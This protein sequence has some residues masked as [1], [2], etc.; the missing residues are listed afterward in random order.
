MFMLELFVRGTAIALAGLTLAPL[1][2]R[3]SPALRHLI[4]AIGFGWLA[5][6][7]LQGVAGPRWRPA[8]LP[9]AQLGSPG[10]N[11][12]VW[13]LAAVAR[14]KTLVL[15]QADGAPGT[16][17]FAARSIPVGSVLAGLAAAG[18]LLLLGLRG[19]GMWRVRRLIGRGRTLDA[20]DPVSRMAAH[21]AHT[22]GLAKPIP[23][24]ETAKCAAPFAAGIARPVIVI[25]AEFRTW[26][27][28]RREAVLLHEAAHVARCDPWW[29]AL[30]EVALAVHWW[31]PVVRFAVRAGVTA[32]ELAADD[33]V[34]AAG[35]APERYADDLVGLSRTLRGRPLIAAP[36]LHLSRS[37]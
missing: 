6:L 11:E 15:D 32:S 16:A 7:P 4:L 14:A 30:G 2:G 9:A 27:A 18:T 17:A 3:R 20:G 34:V 37:D 8:V 23:I 13:D 10:G 28:A 25:P 31:N 19:V 22:V 29:R 12:V 26:P 36:V 1:A 33:Q 5:L 35:V 21:A 24:V